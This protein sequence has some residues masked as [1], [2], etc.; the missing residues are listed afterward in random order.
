MND[1][2]LGFRFSLTNNNEAMKFYSNLSETEKEAISNYLQECSSSNKSKE[3][4]NNA[5]NF[6]QNKNI[7]FI[8]N[9]NL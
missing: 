7:S 2:P 8:E 6:L 9:S 3:K 4:I 1:I 5:I